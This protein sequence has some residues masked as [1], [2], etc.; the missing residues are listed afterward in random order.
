MPR[1]PSVS[2][3]TLRRLL[4]LARDLLQAPD[5]RS[6]LELAGPAIQELLAA[7][8][9]LLLVSPGGHEYITEFDRSGSMQPAREETAL[10]RHARLA[11][12]NQ[13]PILLPDVAADPRLRANGLPA[14]ETTMSLLAYPFPPIMPIGVLA[15]FWC[16]KGRQHQLAKQISTLRYIGELTGAALGNIAFRQVLEGQVM[17]GTKEI[18]EAAQEHEKELRRRDHLE[19]E[20]HRISVTDVLT[21]MLNRRGFFLHAERSF[22]VARRQRIPSALIFA[23]IDGLKAVNDRLGHDAGDRLIQD[24]ARILQDS[25]RD[26]DVV[27]RLGGDEFAAFTLGSTEPQVILARIEENIEGLRRRSSLPYHISFSTGIVQC[28]PSSDLTLSDYLSLA[29]KQMYDQKKGRSK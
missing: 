11:M 10:Y 12:A 13:T 14:D 16:R 21:G 23:D 25:F 22:R 9:A 15:A 8:G 2:A 29:D 17:A 20:I 5:P 18:A 4:A 7:D 3:A 1:S 6:V 19:E 24:G 26:S 27:A 28:D